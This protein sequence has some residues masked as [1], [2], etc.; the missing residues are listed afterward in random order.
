MEKIKRILNKK[1][2]IT[3]FIILAI[4][5]LAVVLIIFYPRI[6]EALIPPTPIQM[7]PKSC[8]ESA[9]KEGL[10]QT[11]LRGGSINPELY[12]KYNNYTLQYLCYTSEWYETCVMQEP[13]LKQHIEAEVQSYS[14]AEIA[15]CMDSM[16]D[17]LKAR[18]YEVRVSGSKEGII[19][20]EPDKIKVSFDLNIT[21]QR[22]DVV[23]SILSDR[24][25][26]RFKSKAY[27]IIMISTSILNYEARFGDSVPE[28]YMSYYPNLKVEKL[29]QSDGTKVYKLTERETGELF[30]FATRSKAWPPG[31]GEPVTF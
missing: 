22:N 11:M 19:T 25:D 6:K 16:L 9:V 4:A 29:K 8:V 24:F 28:I 13:L 5:I 30:Q 23:E 7:I 1:S 26:M 15:S 31:Y 12:F 3:I 2:Q 18:G 27:D 10:N 14:G 21:L 20:L 17:S